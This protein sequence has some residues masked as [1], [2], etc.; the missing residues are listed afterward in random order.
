[1]ERTEAIKTATEQYLAVA[2]LIASDRTRYGI[3]I[4]EIENEYLQNRN[5]TSV[6]GTYP[7][8][9]AEA[10]D[11]LCNYKKDPKNLARLLGQQLAG[12]NLSSGVAFAQQGKQLDGHNAEATDNAAFAT[13]GASH[14]VRKKVCKRCG[15]DNHTSVECDTSP[16]K[17]WLHPGGIANILS[18]VNM[19]AKYHVTYDSHTGDH[20]NIFCVHK[21]DGEKR[22]FKQSRRGL[23][24][25]DTAG[26]TNH[27]FVVL[28]STVGNTNH[29]VLV[30]T[31]ADNKS[32][33]TDRD[34]SRAQLARKIQILI[35]RP[36][37]R[38]YLRYITNNAIPNCPIG[39]QDAINAADI[40]GRDIGSLKGKTTRRS[41]GGIRAGVIN[42]PRQIMAQY[43]NITLCIDLMFVN[44]IPFFVSISRNIKFVTASVLSNRKEASLVKL[45]TRIYGIY[46]KRGFRIQNILGDS[47]FEC[48]RSAVASILNSELNICGEDEHVPAI[49]QC[50]G[51]VKE[52]I[53]CT[54]TVAP[55]NYFPPKMIT[56]MVFLNIFWLNAFPHKLG[57]SQTLSP[58]TLITG[59]GIDY[60]KHCRVKY[61]QY[62]QTHEKHD[63]SMAT[64]TVGALALRPTGNLQGGHYFY[65]LITGLRLHRTHWTEL[66]MPTEVK[67]RVHALARGVNAN[68]GL[69]FTDSNGND[70]DAL[71]PDDDA[72]SDY[73]PDDDT[74]SYASSED[75]DF[76]PAAD[77]ASSDASASQ[78]TPIPDLPLA[79]PRELAGVT[80]NPVDNTGVHDDTVDNTGVH[81][82][83]P[84]DNTGVN[85]NPVDKTGVDEVHTDIEAFVHELESELDNEIDDLDSL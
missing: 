37:L 28:V 56:E 69:T 29:V 65:S 71:F 74:L 68:R 35:G 67:D 34:Y 59:L 2:F 11:Y 19:I 78:A 8:T 48:T 49:E 55:F 58:R 46:Q 75:S 77:D 3:L 80:A 7:T 76:A 22:L 1:V 12:D 20:P 13:S 27:V 79:V 33:Y 52:R 84:V 41:L 64:R 70:L 5:A 60:T 62:V 25:L 24:Y 44:K 23:F 32:K 50:I 39:R 6:V 14:Q 17:V 82:D 15:I 43:R 54:Y 31:V 83:N 36:E 53:R 63:N 21:G 66:P 81:D 45:L 4:E 47:E 18:L 30:S 38:D 26:N 16:E 57:V 9:V 73:N 85:A 10:Y 40:F 42:I 72:D 51:T 61:S